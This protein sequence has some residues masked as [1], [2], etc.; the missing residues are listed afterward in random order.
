[1]DSFNLS[2]DIKVVCVTAKHFPEDV[3]RAHIQLHAMLPEK[4]KRRF[5]GISRTNEQGQIVYKAA[6]DLIEPG[7]A[8]K[9]GLEMFTIKKGTFNSFYIKNF[10]EDTSRIR[11]AFQILLGQPEVDPLGY[12]L[13]WY[14]GENDVKCMVPLDEKQSHFTG[15]ATE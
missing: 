2:E 6:A 11:E 4:E 8:E 3:E 14:I 5:F 15:V 1:M 9:Y 13:E 10:M 12:C 7:E